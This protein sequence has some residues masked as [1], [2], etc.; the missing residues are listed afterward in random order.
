MV[1]F[2][3]CEINCLDLE[4]DIQIDLNYLVTLPSMSKMFI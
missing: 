3:Q 1:L 4:Q 2:H